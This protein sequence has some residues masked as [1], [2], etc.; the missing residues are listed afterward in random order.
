MV[1]DRNVRMSKTSRP[2]MESLERRR[3]L[4]FTP[5]ITASALVADNSNYGVAQVD[6]HLMGPWGLA[7]TGNNELWSA[8]NK[9]GTLTAYSSAG[10]PQPS[11]ANQLV[12]TVPPTVAGATGTPTGLVAHT[13]KGFNV[14]VNGK[15]GPS[16]FLM[17][18]EDG[19]ILGYS[20]VASSTTAA[21]AVNH[22]S[23]G[24]VFKGLTIIGAG[25]SARIYATDFHNGRVEVFDSNFNPVTLKASAFTDPEVPAGYAPFGIQ[26]ING[27]IYVSYARQD[28]AKKFDNPG[29]A[30]GIVDIYSSR[31]KLKQRV[32]TGGDLNSPWGMVL[33]P[34]TWGVEK[35]DLLVSNVGDGSIS[36]FDKHANF[37]GQVPDSATGGPLG[38][39]GLRS[40]TLGTKKFRNTLF[41]TSAPNS[42]TDGILGTLTAARPAKKPH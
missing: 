5:V 29:P 30:Q 41:F 1:S 42:Q 9:T 38:I 23:T 15:T 20:L 35:G 18:T 25:R 37:I 32:G 36:I 14:T 31:G 3:L 17:A 26:A 8:N 24:D 27:N 11:A 7:V 12:A 22:S 6:A 16:D 34:S 39:T 2:R 21:I 4:A 19:A 10:I 33:A 13:G 28:A 40:L